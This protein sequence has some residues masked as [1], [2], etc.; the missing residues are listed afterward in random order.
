MSD[1]STHPVDVVCVCCSECVDPSLRLWCQSV[2]GPLLQA[3]DC[4][5]KG[6]GRQMALPLELA[7]SKANGM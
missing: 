7:L 4:P 3:I 1:C 5:F 6:K 2:G